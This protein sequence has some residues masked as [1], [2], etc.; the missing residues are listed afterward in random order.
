MFYVLF[1]LIQRLKTF[2]SFTQNQLEIDYGDDYEK[3]FDFLQYDSMMLRSIIL[4]SLQEI[5]QVFG[6][7]YV[8]ATVYK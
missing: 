8:E 6:F 1:P 5:F 7:K 4:L 2:C 3:C